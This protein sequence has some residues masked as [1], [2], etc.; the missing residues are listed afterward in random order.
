MIRPATPAEEPALAR[1]QSRL[2]EPSPGLLDAWASD[3]VASP[4]E[5]LVSATE[6]GRPA[7]YLLAV[8]GNGTA[9]VAELVVAPGHRREGRA[10][11]LLSA[12]VADAEGSVT[13]TVTPDNEAARALYRDCGFERVRRL[14][15][16]FQRGD[17]VLYRRD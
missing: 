6:A 14:P 15:G 17:A 11:A 7:G 10:T 4:V 12:Y 3:A 2:P 8:P 5:V 16:F 1:L 9:Y 13:V